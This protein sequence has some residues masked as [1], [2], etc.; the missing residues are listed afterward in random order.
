MSEMETH[1]GRFK[2]ICANDKDT[3]KYIQDNLGEWWKINEYGD[4]EWEIDETHEYVEKYWRL[5]I[6]FEYEVIYVKDEHWLIKYD[7]HKKFEDGDTIGEMTLNP[8]GTY[9][10]FTQFYNG[11]TCLEEMLGEMIE[12]K[13][14]KE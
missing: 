13:I 9:D 1:I 12:E 7:K 11:G 10:F 4:G 14:I 5:G 6:P 8:D 2:I 3:K